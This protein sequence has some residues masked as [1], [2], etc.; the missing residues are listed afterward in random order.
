MLMSIVCLGYVF[1]YIKNKTIYTSTLKIIINNIYKKIRFCG[2]RIMNNALK[3]LWKMIYQYRW[4]YFV[5]MLAPIVTAFYPVL[6]NYSVKLLLD[7]LTTV[8]NFTYMDL[9][10]PIVLFISVQLLINIVWRISNIVEWKIE[11]IVRQNIVITSYNYVQHHSYKFFLDNFPG[12]ITSKL[13]GLLDGYDR[14][15]EQ[16]RHGLSISLLS[17]VINMVALFL[18]STKVGIFMSI[19]S[20]CFLITI[21]FL[22][23]RLNYLSFEETQARHRLVGTLADKI[24]NISALFSFATKESELNDLKKNV[25][26]DFMP[27]QVAQ[28]R[29]SFVVQ[30]VAGLLYLVMF[31]SLLFMMIE[32]R[33]QGEISIG[34]F[35]FVFGIAFSL[36]DNLWKL[37]NN[38]QSF[39]Y[40]L[41][42]LISSFE[43]LNVEHESKDAKNAKILKVKK[44]GVV[45]QNLYFSYDSTKEILKDININIKPGEKVGLVGYSGAGKST[46]INT[47]LRYFDAT[48]GSIKIDD[49]DIRSVTGDSLRAN[50][51]MIPQDNILFHR[52]IIENIRYGRETA[53]DEEVIEVSKKSFIHD[54]IQSLPEGYNT[55]VGDRGFKLSSGQRQRIA[56]A[57][58]IL[59]DAPILILDEATSS[60]D[61]HTEKEIQD[62][63]NILIEDS[64]K[65]VI[66]IA[67]RLS[68]LKHMDRIIVLDNGRIEEEGTHAQLIKNRNSLYNKLW[69]LQKI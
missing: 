18:V 45:L 39:V 46:L 42:D 59:K 44:G 64:K 40:E 50:I 36:S 34:D 66:A 30:L 11:P 20:I 29:Y 37:I 27:R 15:W 48:S 26:Q 4:H 16:L 7:I 2:E 19:W 28:Y 5:M 52:S 24:T 12:N 67:H 68:T 62:S 25:T 38:L 32:A 55:I 43:F 63:L 56:I 49:Q 9:L 31:I 17:N 57:R 8:E 3:F 61:S 51:S 41:G 33:K 23:K 13:K 22:L 1:I 35:V 65:T 58:A 69:K 10:Y 6:Y 53:T 60:L 21:Y 54:A 47:I 14:L